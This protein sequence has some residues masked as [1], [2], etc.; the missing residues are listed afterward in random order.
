MSDYFSFR[1]GRDETPR[2]MKMG[3]ALSQLINVTFLPNHKNTTANESISGRAYRLGWRRTERTVNVIF[4]ALGFGGHHCHRA[5][6]ADVE[7]AQQTIRNARLAYRIDA[8]GVRQ[9]S[10]DEGLK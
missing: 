2:V 10:G 3:D 7:R 6:R 8:E 9:M 5:Y 4:W 1:E